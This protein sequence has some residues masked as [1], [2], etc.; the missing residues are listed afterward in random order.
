MLKV[1]KTRNEECKSE[2]K[3]QHQTVRKERMLHPMNTS[4]FSANEMVR[5]V[6]G[7]YE[8]FQ[9]GYFETRT[10]ATYR[11]HLLGFIK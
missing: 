8:R 11:D 1:S 2:E 6:R 3:R 4:F 5:F 9:V 7:C 10:H